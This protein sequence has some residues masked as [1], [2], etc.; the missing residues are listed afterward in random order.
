[1]ALRLPRR[2]RASASR[3]GMTVLRRTVS[4]MEAMAG[5]RRVRVAGDLFHG[6]VPPGAVYVGRRRRAC[7]RARTG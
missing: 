5:P 4:G 2:P 3:P 7:P 6:R 1:M